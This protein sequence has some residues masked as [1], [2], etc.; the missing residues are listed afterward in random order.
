[1]LVARTTSKLEEVAAEAK[2][3]FRKA[4]PTEKGLEVVLISQDLSAVGAAEKVFEASKVSLY[5]VPTKKVLPLSC[6]L[7]FSIS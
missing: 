6:L 2:E 4:N 1:M 5:F 3:I 7:S